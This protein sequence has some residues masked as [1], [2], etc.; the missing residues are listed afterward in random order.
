MN[1]DNVL[2]LIMGLLVGFIAGYL[3]HEVMASRQP[4]RLVS[5]AQPAAQTAAAP[6]A[7]TPAS[8]PAAGG[9]DAKTAQIRE[10]E[11]HL[12]SHPDDAQAL[13][14]LANL[15]YDVQDWHKC[16]DAYDRYLKLR[17]EDPDTLTDQGTCY[18]GV[19][20]P[21]K[22]LDLFRRAEALDPNH[23]QSRFNEVVV[24]AFDLKDF[25]GAE[26]VLGKLR[27]LQPNNPDVQHL[28]DEVAR[29]R[30]AA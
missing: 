27:A 18:R 7:P 4:P 11:T 15:S 24:L 23:W 6:Q 9:L 12:A 2:F 20:E 25:A 22:A 17:P 10:I 16:V 26:R 8:G 21:H 29:R 30:G 13:L 14:S 3:L 19:G 1:R 28:A 5:Q